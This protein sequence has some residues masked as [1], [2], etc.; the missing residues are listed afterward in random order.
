MKKSIWH[1]RLTAMVLSGIMALSVTSS[2]VLAAESM[3]LTLE[4]GVK[5]ALENNRSI[6]QSEADA[7]SAQWALSEAKGS[8]GLTLS[9]NSTA[10]RVG[11]D[12]VGERDKDYTNTL[13][14]QL[15]IY[16]GGN[17]ENKVKKAKL[18]VDVSS[19]T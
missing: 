17:L 7:D 15:P 16:S 3:N 10:N 13:S 19:L 4:E 11:G 6:Q 5:L 2:P 14:A 9:W 1:K 18:G 12:S 8:K